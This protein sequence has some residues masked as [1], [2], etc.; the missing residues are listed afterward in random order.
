M[1]PR[2]FFSFFTVAEEPDCKLS[3]SSGDSF[4]LSG[5]GIGLALARPDLLGSS[6]S[7][8]TFKVSFLPVVLLIISTFTGG[9]DGKLAVCVGT[10]AKRAPP[11]FDLVLGTLYRRFGTTG[12]G[13]SNSI[14][15]V[16]PCSKFGRTL[17]YLDMP[18]R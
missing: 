9:F 8:G 13:L 2:F 1:R 6:C 4:E 18:D 11:A 10:N 16:R 12:L 15:L 17:C 3:E 14:E 7:I 5:G